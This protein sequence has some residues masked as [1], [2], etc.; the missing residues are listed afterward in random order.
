MAVIKAV[1]GGSSLGRALEY[2]GREGITSGKDCPDKTQEAIIQMKTTKEIYGQTAGRQY[3]HYV[4]SFDPK[5]VIEPEKA[6]LLGREWAEKCFPGY[7]VFVGTHHDKEHLHNHIIVNSVNFRHGRKIQISGRDLERFKDENDLI[8]ER[9]GFSIPKK[10]NRRSQIITWDMNK[11]KLFE[12]INAG[13][14]I[15]SYVLDTAIAVQKAAQ[16]SRN[17]AEFMLS[18]QRAGYKINWQDNRKNVTFRDRDGNKVRLSNLEKT[19]N[20]RLFTK[21]GLQNEFSRTEKQ[22]RIEKAVELSMGT[23][24]N[25]SYRGQQWDSGIK[26]TRTGRIASSRVY[27]T[28]K[29]IGNI[30]RKL[31]R[32]EEG[33]RPSAG[34]HQRAIIRDRDKDRE[35][36]RE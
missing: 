23:G 21:E 17:K 12:R 35:Y 22:N 32:L 33:A 6:N 28:E 16:Q 13:E 15:R 26:S 36:E 9:E 29:I 30:S 4:Q 24:R 20:D 5:D 34:K 7:E 27:S 31:Q 25:G 19:F 11:Q 10:G 8:C 14:K 18:M 1:K 2:A 3:K